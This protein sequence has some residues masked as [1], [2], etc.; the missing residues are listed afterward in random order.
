[1]HAKNK[2]PIAQDL[3]YIC[4][5]EGR[6]REAIEAFSIAIKTGPSSEFIFLERADLLEKAGDLEGAAKDRAAAKNARTSF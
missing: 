6:V 3:G 1:M 5:D 2:A 4:R